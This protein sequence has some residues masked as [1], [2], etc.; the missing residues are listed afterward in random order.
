MTGNMDKSSRVQ[1]AHK[2]A[3]KSLARPGMKQATETE[4]LIFI[5]PIYNH[6]WRN[7]SEGKCKGLPQQAEVT[8][9]VPG[10][11][12]PRFS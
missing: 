1:T 6:N 9:G 4:I 10:R 11:L 12:R 8:Q 7:I 2:G 3:G 5:Y